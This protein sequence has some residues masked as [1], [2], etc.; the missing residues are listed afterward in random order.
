MPDVK[1]AKPA[2]AERLILAGAVVALVGSA[3][4]TLYLVYGTSDSARGPGAASGSILWPVLLGCAQFALLASGWWLTVRLVLVR[5]VRA[6]H[7]AVEGL[8][9]GQLNEPI[10]Y[11]ARD[12]LSAF[13]S[14]MDDLRAQLDQSRREAELAKA[15][16]DDAN[17]S[18]QAVVGSLKDETGSTK[19]LFAD[20]METTQEMVNRLDPELRWLASSRPEVTFLGW[21]VE[22]LQRMRFLDVVHP[23]DREAARRAFRKAIDG[24]EMHGLAC[25][26]VRRDRSVRHVQ[27]N[28]AARYDGNRQCIA[29]RCH[30]QDQTEKVRA[31]LALKQRT[32]QLAAANA[33]LRKTNHE[34]E[35]MKN[36]YSDLY[37][38]SPVMYY[39]LDAQGKITGC[40][41]RMVAVLGYSS[42]EL[43][44][45]PYTVL[46]ADPDAK[47]FDQTIE[48]LKQTGR[49][50]RDWQWRR[51]DDSR[52]DVLV[53]ASAM[54][55]AQG[56]LVQSRNVAQD[57]TER[58]RLS[59]QLEEEAQRLAEA[60]TLLKKAN[61]E[62]DDFTYMVSHDL[63]EPLRTIEAFSRFL[64]EDYH[65]RLD[66]P[67]RKHLRYLGDASMRLRSLIDQVLTLS[68][69]GRVANVSEGIDMQALLGDVRSDLDE[70]LRTRRA[71]LVLPDDVPPI[72]A[73]R[74]R[75]AEVLRNLITNGIRYNQNDEPTVEVRW[76]WGE[77]RGAAPA[78][79]GADGPGSAPSRE[80]IF[81]V[82]DNGMGIK[83][84]HQQKI[85]KLFQRLHRREEYAGAG[86]GLA[87]C[88]KIVEAHGGKLT[89]ESQPGQGST[90]RF[91][92]VTRTQPSTDPHVEGG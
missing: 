81:S 17:R 56:R 11:A 2:I 26:V 33:Q 52:M 4:A 20:P 55:D 75:I 34:L 82:R 16:L 51:K 90:F 8:D 85:F 49:V 62:L 38:N 40:N 7:Q 6:L 19:S 57:V 78:G 80:I 74:Q 28:A 48:N 15:K 27:V 45:Q 9:R 59:V 10:V 77:G 89:V 61:T 73:D 63:K 3:A 70:L 54:L 24:G 31:E 35:R 22:H 46:L 36:R 25:R 14:R 91:S 43:T 37:H 58:K 30:M 84:E 41:N 88:Q 72:W 87:I 18:L 5:R 69:I 71:R 44:G 79:A 47:A 60:N 53:R 64:I 21:P 83:P 1:Q 65:D 23:E 76:E 39:S 86:A 92:L 32:E 42:E 67:G 68:R 12:E 66:E 50:E 29:V 13:A